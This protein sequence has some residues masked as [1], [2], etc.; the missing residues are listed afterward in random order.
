M[1]EVSGGLPVR[2]VALSMEEYEGMELKELKI[3]PSQCFKLEISRELNM[4]LLGQT[5]SM[6]SYP[7]Q[8][9]TKKK[10]PISDKRLL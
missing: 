5:V 9:Y 2:F 10:E 8:S 3:F 4:L 7:G 1:V 6:W